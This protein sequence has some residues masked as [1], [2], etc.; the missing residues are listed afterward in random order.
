MNPY[1]T[2]PEQEALWA[3]QRH[4]CLIR[5]MIQN[6]TLANRVLAEKSEYWKEKDERNQKAVEYGKRLFEELAQWIAK[7]PLEGR[8]LLDRWDRIQRHE[9]RNGNLDPNYA[10]AM[11]ERARQIWFELN[12]VTQP[13][14]DS[15]W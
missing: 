4:E 10:E 8:S 1:Q 9:R 13:C 7:Q 3:K 15:M 12:E 6:P 2:T 14:Q 5:A 11:R